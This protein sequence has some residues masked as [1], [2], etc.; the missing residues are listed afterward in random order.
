MN[1]AHDRNKRNDRSKRNAG[2]GRFEGGAARGT[3]ARASRDSPCLPASSH[4]RRSRRVDVSPKDEGQEVEA[5][6]LRVARTTGR[7]ASRGCSRTR[8]PSSR[9]PSRGRWASSRCPTCRCS[10]R[11]GGRVRPW[12]PHRLAR[13]ARVSSNWRRTSGR[14]SRGGGDDVSCLLVRNDPKV[15]RGKDEGQEVEAPGLRVARSSVVATWCRRRPAR[16]AFRWVR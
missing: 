12:G 10:R 14:G 15:S 6:G 7:A 8:A 11:R 4:V 16:R 3:M 5:P 2:V 13:I 1:L 9:A